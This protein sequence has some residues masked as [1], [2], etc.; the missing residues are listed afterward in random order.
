MIQT[1]VAVYNAPMR[2]LMWLGLVMLPLG[3]GPGKGEPNS[4]DDDGTSTATSTSGEGESDTDEPSTG[5][6]ST[7]EDEDEGETDSGTETGEPCEPGELDCECLPDGTC[8][9]FEGYAVGCGGGICGGCGYVATSASSGPCRPGDCPIDC[10]IDYV[11]LGLAAPIPPYSIPYTQVEWMNMELPYLGAECTGEDGWAWII[12]GEQ[13]GLCGSHCD[14]W[15]NPGEGIT[16][17][18][19]VGCPPGEG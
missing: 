17:D 3:C 11:D 6:T 1:V 2:R 18:V 13:L 4:G 9:P 8:L 7:T 10:L 14:A 15:M 5:T 16:F 12:P 19:T